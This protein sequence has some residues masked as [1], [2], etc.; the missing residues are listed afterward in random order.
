M[1]SSEYPRPLVSVGSYSDYAGAQ[2][3]V[4][5]LSDRGFPVERLQIVGSDMR[6]VEQITG[7]RGYAQAAFGG[8][9]TGAVVGLVFGWFLG[10]F[11]LAEPLV[12]AF[13]LALWGV[14]I[15]AVVGAILGMIGHALSGGRRDFSSIGGV[16]ATRYDVMADPQVADEAVRL[17]AEH[18]PS[19]TSG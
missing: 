15:G 13:V 18:E 14:V 8:A 4:D 19:R 10:L 5:A 3:A 12:S 11:S 16:E 1:S 9:G 6:I 2:A 7:R 17:L